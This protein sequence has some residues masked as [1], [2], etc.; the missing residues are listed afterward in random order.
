MKQYK[1]ELGQLCFGNPVGIY[2]LPEYV[3]AYLDYIYYEID[4]VYWNRFQKEREEHWNPEIKEIEHREYYWGDEK[5][6]AEKP[7]FKFK[8]VE[9]R[10]YKHKGRGMSCNKE[11]TTDEWKDWFNDCLKIIRTYDITYTNFYDI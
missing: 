2:E 3:A 9:I 4:R 11:L 1:P 10:W 8:D 6:E 5:K 7:N